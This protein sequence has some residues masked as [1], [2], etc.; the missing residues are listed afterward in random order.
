MPLR[1]TALLLL[2]RERSDSL[3]TTF[4]RMKRPMA[5]MKNATV[6][7]AYT[8]SAMYLYEKSQPTFHENTEVHFFFT[9][10]NVLPEVPAMHVVFALLFGE[11]IAGEGPAPCQLDWCSEPTGHREVLPFKK[12]GSRSVLKNNLT[13]RLRGDRRPGQYNVALSNMADGEHASI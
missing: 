12:D 4:P 5:H 1:Q 8:W 11:A 10:G 9:R 7:R 13:S 2:L 6:G 3:E